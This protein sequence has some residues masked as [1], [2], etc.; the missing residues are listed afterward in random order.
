M[1]QAGVCLRQDTE[2]TLPELTEQHR[3]RLKEEELSG[4]ES[5]TECAAPGLN[6]LEPECVTAHSGVSDGHHTHTSVIKTEADLGFTHTGDLI[7]TESPERTELGYVTHL[8]PDQIKTEAEDGGYLKAEHISDF[9]DFKCFNIKCESSE[10]LVSDLMNTVMT[11]AGVDHTDQT[12]PWQCAGE[13]NSN[14]KKEEIQ[15]PLTQFG[16]LNHH[17]NINNENNQTNIFHKR[18][19]GCN[20]DGKLTTDVKNEPMIISTRERQYTCT[21]CEKCFNTKSGLTAHR[22]I[23]TG[24]KPYSCPHCENGFHFKYQ[25]T[26]HLRIHTDEKP[27]KCSQCGKCFSKISCRNRHQRIHTGEKAYKCSDCGKCFSIRSDLNSHQIIHTHEK[28]YKCPQ[29]EKCFNFKS[30]LTAHQRI[31]T[32]EKPYNCPQCEKCFYRIAC[33]NRHQ[34]IHTG[35]KPYKCPQCGKC[36]YTIVCLNRHQ[37]IHTDEKPYKCSLCGKCFSIRSHL[38]SHQR[39]HTGEKP[40]KCPQC[41]KCFHFKS[42]LT[43]HLRIHTGEKPYK[44]SECG[45][46]FSIRSRLNSHQRIHTGEKPHKRSVWPVLPQKISV[47]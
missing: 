1:M 34:R 29:C 41:E 8:H 17:S 45:K 33:L 24:E 35:E 32:G 43:T 21:V 38:N 46:C 11:G 39:M 26:T 42:G 37:T 6:T 5:E 9:Q 30:G 3:I 4:L 15:D 27:Y 22:R 16:D 40:Y 36:F 44:C 20:Q 25:L 28:P 19:N 18:T 31:H 10:G 13:P 7:K 14:C 47:K 2:T 23:H 12:E